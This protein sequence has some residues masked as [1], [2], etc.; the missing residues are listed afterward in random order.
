MVETPIDTPELSFSRVAV[1]Y[2]PRKT[3]VQ[4]LKRAVL[5]QQHGPEPS[6]TLWYETSIAESGKDH[7]LAALEAGADLVIASGGDGT[8]RSIAEGL[9]GSGVPLGIVPQGTGNILARN[10]GI[11][12]RHINDAVATV[13]TGKT[14]SIDLGVVN[15]VRKSGYQDEHVFL[16]LAGL[17]IDAKAIQLTQSGLKKRVG[18]LAYVE[19]GVRAL[20]VQKPIKIRYQIDSSA[21][22]SMS[23]YSVM[24][25]NCGLMPGGVLLIP[26]AKP[27]DGILDLVALRPRSIF[28]WFNIGRI[29]GWENG[30]LRRT[31][32]GRRII[33]LTN[34]AKEVSYFTGR[35]FE[36]TLDRPEA[37]QLDG[38]EFGEAVAAHGFVD[39]GAL[40][41]RVP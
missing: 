24:I 16:V 31:K 15:I 25:G 36:V 27:D 13:F 10:L 1:I 20:I 40:L 6:E 4:A 35:T 12:L 39:P 22:S 37:V 29:I 18:W 34:D 41:V 19:G 9:R 14:R 26:N 8:V 38:D 28:S 11:E 30:V 7:A 17:G 3:G 32:T 23:V 21:K 2:H 5:A 33:D